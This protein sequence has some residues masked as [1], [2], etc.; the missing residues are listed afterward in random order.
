MILNKGRILCHAP[1]VLSPVSCV[2]TL[3]EKVRNFQFPASASVSCRS[4]GAEK[5]SQQKTSICYQ[6]HT[7][8]I[9]E[10]K[11]GFLFSKLKNGSKK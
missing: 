7:N 1:C 5:L 2:L 3:R 4:V 9:I 6:G 11:I 8:Q 10:P